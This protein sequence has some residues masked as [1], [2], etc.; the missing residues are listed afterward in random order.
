MKNIRLTLLFIVFAMFSMMFICGNNIMFAH[1]V[2]SN[3]DTMFVC[4]LNLE[5][6][7]TTQ[8]DKAFNINFLFSENIVQP[9][10]NVKTYI[11]TFL[12]YDGKTLLSKTLNHGTLP[13]YDGTPTRASD[14]CYTYLFI[15][16]NKELQPIEQDTTYVACYKKYAKMQNNTNSF[17]VEEKMGNYINLNKD[18]LSSVNKPLKLLFK[19]VEIVFPKS[20]C[21]NL[22][23]MNSDIQVVVNYLSLNMKN[24]Q[25]PKR[26]TFQVLCDG[27]ELKDLDATIKINYYFKDG[28]KEK[29]QVI[30]GEKDISDQVSYENGMIILTVDKS[31]DFVFGVRYDAQMDKLIIFGFVV[32]FGVAIIILIICAIIRR[33]KQQLY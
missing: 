23:S 13:V 16:W 29:L 5:E 7:H 28:V 21:S 3:A 22:S 32:V 19:D 30:S 33:K 25:N 14:A 24:Y 9:Q 8:N 26:F 17:V 18:S 4:G 31:Q 10:D 11:C 6:E 1:G 2:F 12:D 20:T 15:G 27:N